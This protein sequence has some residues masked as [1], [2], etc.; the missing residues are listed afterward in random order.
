MIQSSPEPG[1]EVIS[2]K[3]LARDYHRVVQTEPEPM[4]CRVLGGCSQ[5]IHTTVGLRSLTQSQCRT[6]RGTFVM[7]AG[8]PLNSA[9]RNAMSSCYQKHTGAWPVPHTGTLTAR[10]LGFTAFW[11]VVSWTSWTVTLA[12][13]SVDGIQDLG[14]CW[15]K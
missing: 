3:V 15:G 14:D 10:P 2:R 1:E 4:A 13:D 12:R 11:T 7:V 6:C 8:T 5:P 9:P